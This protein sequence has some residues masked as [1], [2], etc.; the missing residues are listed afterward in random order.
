MI[1]IGIGAFIV[2]AIFR[3]TAETDKYPVDG[4]MAFT[5]VLAPGLLSFLVNFILPTP[6][7]YFA[8]LLY[9]IVPTLFLALGLDTPWKSAVWRGFIVFSVIAGLS[10]ISVLITGAV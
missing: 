5:L 2:W 1:T 9:W 6:Y 7:S 3:V 10:V 8:G 4:F